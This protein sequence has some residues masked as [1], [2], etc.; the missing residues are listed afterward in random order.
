MSTHKPGDRYMEWLNVANHGDQ[1]FKASREAY[2]A[3]GR[4]FWVTS[5]EKPVK[6]LGK[7]EAIYYAAARMPD[8]LLC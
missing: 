5:D 4:R 6:A 7:S 2:E 3:T 1:M 8:L